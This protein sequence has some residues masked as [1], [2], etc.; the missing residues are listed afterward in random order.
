MVLQSLV[1]SLFFKSFFPLW[2]LFQD[3]AALLFKVIL[4]LLMYIQN[5]TNKLGY[6]LQTRFLLVNCPSPSSS[7]RQR[8]K[9]NLPIGALAGI[10]SFA[11][12]WRM[13]IISAL[14]F[15]NKKQRYLASL[16]CFDVQLPVQ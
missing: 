4:V 11:L 13:A 12:G 16:S 10:S 2:L 9:T 14:V 1:L 5:N 6:R 7:S 15:T 3:C 8:V